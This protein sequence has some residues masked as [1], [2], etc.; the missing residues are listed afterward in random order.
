MWCEDQINNE[1]I[2]PSLESQPFPPLFVETY[3][4]DIMKRL[5]RVYAI[6]YHSFFPELEAKEAAAYLNTSFK[7]FFF[8][9]LN[10]NLVEEVELNA[11]KGLVK[12]L[13]EE[14]DQCG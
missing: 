13:K 1:L 4:K 6:L 8:F 11:M 10:F 12:R 7:H 2:F 14:Y 9:L 5:F 3:V